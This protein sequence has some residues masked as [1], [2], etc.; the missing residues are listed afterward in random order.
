MTI[1][2][3]KTTPNPIAARMAAMDKRALFAVLCVLEAAVCVLD[4]LTGPFI[5]LGPYYVLTIAMAAWFLG[6]GSC[7]FFVV[8]SSMLRTYSLSVL[9]PSN[10]ATLYASDLASSVLVYGVFAFLVLQLK[11][12]YHRLSSYTGV[13]E[14]QVK[15]AEQWYR[16]E[17]GIRR[18]VP[19]DVDEIVRLT[20]LG[21]EDG[22][23]SKD[24]LNT[25][26]QQ[27]LQLAYVDSIQKGAGPRPTW[28]GT[29][30]I[31]PIEF[32]VTEVD[33]RIAGFF[34]IM[35][36][37]QRLGAERE[38][39]AISVARE[40]R[41]MGLGSA[42][43]DFFCSHYYGRRLYVA[44]MPDSRMHCLLKRRGFYHF[45]NTNEGY[46]IVER[47]ERPREKGL[48]NDSDAGHLARTAT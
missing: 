37:D 35:G 27:A 23:L 9:F 41:G 10:A 1:P 33:G 30:E 18:A 5:P 12:A 3:E 8:A 39:H 31:V 4:H 40:F 19:Q 20:V 43:V 14:D 42:M 26:R 48:L 11:H 32:W 38:L 25:V 24:V 36:L 2:P 6:M 46:V 29:N 16:I 22:D 44:C 15:Q 34:M 21:A 28:N 7:V 47:V 17:S 13:L 45:A